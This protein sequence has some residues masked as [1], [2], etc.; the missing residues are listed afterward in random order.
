MLLAA[1]TMAQ[2][3]PPAPLLVTV[4]ID[5]LRPDYVT[6][7]GKSLGLVDERDVAPT[8]AHAAGRSLP[9]ADGKS[10]LP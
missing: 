2:R 7:A 5:G 9:S 6:P 4:P 10:L 8:L 3:S 1:V